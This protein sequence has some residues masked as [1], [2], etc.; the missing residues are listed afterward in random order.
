MKRKQQCPPHHWFI[1]RETDDMVLARCMCCTARQ[2]QPMSGSKESL[3]R[4]NQLNKKCH[5]P[6]IKVKKRK[7]LHKEPL[8]DDYTT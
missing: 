7:S 1:G 5:Y 3:K 4:A 2:Y 8:I 6:L